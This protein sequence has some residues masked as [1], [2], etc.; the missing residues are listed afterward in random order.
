MRP[1]VR[2][3]STLNSKTPD[4]PETP[5]PF[6]PSKSSETF[7]GFVALALWVLRLQSR[8]VRSWD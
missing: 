6:E 8:L 4:R 2:Q 5:N 3:R 7:Q 1:S